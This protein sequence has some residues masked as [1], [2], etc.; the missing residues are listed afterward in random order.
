MHIGKTSYSDSKKYPPGSFMGRLKERKIIATFVAFAGSGVVIIEVAHHILVNHYHLPQQI[1]DICIVTL[2]GALLGTLLWRWFRG[3]EKRPGNVKVEVLVVPL[4]ILL[5]L[6][7]DLKFIFLMTDIS[8]SMMLIGIVALGLGIAWIIFKS[9]QWAANV[10]EMGKKVEVLKPIEEKPITSRE[11]TVTFGFKRLFIPTLVILAIAVI[12]LII[13]S[14][15]AQKELVQI[16]KEKPSIAVL[17][18]NDL[19]PQKDQQY[20]CDGLAE[21][22]I[23]ALTHISE[24]HVVARTSAFSF[25]GEKLDVR[26]IGQKLNVKTVLEGS[27]QK[28]GNRIR[29]TAQLINIID[30]Y[31]LWSEKYDRNMEDIFDIQ[32][33][34]SLAIVDNLKVK[35]L[36]REK[37]A[38]VKRYTDDLDAYDLYLKGRFY[39]EMFTPKGFEEAVD[40]FEKALE[41]DSNFALAYVGLGAV[42]RYITLMGN[43][44]PN[45]VIPKMRTYAEKALEID[46]NLGDAHCLLA[47]Y[48]MNYD[49]DWYAAEE[50]LKQAL[51]LNP[52]SSY[53]HFYQSLFLLF[54][55]RHDD[56]VGAVKR[57][58]ELDPLSSLSHF[59]I[60]HILY[61]AGRYDES[62][63]EVQSLLTMNPNYYLPHFC[64]GYNYRKK[65]LM[66]KA[67]AEYEKAYTLSGGVPWAA[68]L[69][70]TA[71]YETGNE[72][73]ARKLLINLEEKSK[74]EY[75]A[76]VC[77]YFIHRTFGNS[78][79][80]S[81]W[82]E[83]AYQE[84]DGFL[85]Y[86][87]VFPDNTY[88]IPP[89]PRL[90]EKLEKGDKIDRE[91][92]LSLQD[93]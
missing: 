9:L 11:I 92:H 8:I 43:L 60:G 90:T 27:L 26:E 66:K 28:V 61:F 21:T 57:A 87:R 67:L 41:I 72:D 88:R 1:V 44:P 16:V 79:D 7:I 70:A 59:N 83:K 52:N 22:L 29:I 68:M 35:L 31:H 58:R 86:C 85:G 50:E 93:P 39:A 84:H 54:T 74:H 65:S 6:V 33:E 80:A 5:T 51:H 82:L 14:P 77:F 49:W 45:D 19:S 36:G 75:V 64:L 69:L 34:I 20:F 89:D 15:W 32:D 91:N 56:A 37:A 38:V 12:G 24:L 10:P 73:R 81:Y 40:C 18:F 42:M 63:K 55:E 62:I 23:N 4:I 2:V 71:L 17:S 76:P 53:I 78:D 46:K 13:W 25:K 48:H 3:S 47:S 30:G